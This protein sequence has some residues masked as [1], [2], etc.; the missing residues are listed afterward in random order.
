MAAA[1]AS[2]AGIARAQDLR[3]SP[4]LPTFPYVYETADQKIRVVELADGLAN[5]W[6][7]AWLPNGDL[8]ITERAGRLRVFHAGKLDTAPISGTPEVKITTLGGLLEVLPHPKFADN[9]LLY[10][11]LLEGR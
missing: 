2:T 9:G 4:P 6:S 3:A 11:T 10:F 1:F 7:M 5:P 8:L